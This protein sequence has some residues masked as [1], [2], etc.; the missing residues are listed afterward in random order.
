MKKMLFSGII[1]VLML[2][3]L[4]TISFAG[5]GLKYDR[6]V[7]TP[8]DYWVYQTPSGTSR[9]EFLKMQSDKYVFL[10]NG[11]ETVFDQNLNK[12]DN[13]GKKALQFPISVG[14]HWI[15]N[16]AVNE[17]SHKKGLRKNSELVYSYQ[18]EAFEE[19]ETPAGKFMAFRIEV[20]SQAQTT[21]RKSYGSS[22]HWYAPA[23]G[24]IIKSK[25]GEVILLEFKR[26]EGK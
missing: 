14:E 17:V 11:S 2:I 21:R 25:G 3:G 6:P 5:E 8:G 10:I 18:V 12:T 19:I 15:A 1:A 20:E 26:K 4:S 22:T 7:F 16:V 23:V 13:A 9:H 24:Q